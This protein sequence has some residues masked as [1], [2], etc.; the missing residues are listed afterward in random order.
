MAYLVDYDS[1]T[2]QFTHWT[3]FAYPNGVVGQDYITHFQGISSA[4][5]A[6]TRSAADSGQSGSANA[7]PG[8]V[9]DRPAQSRRLVRSRR[10]GRS[11]LSRRRS[12]H[13]RHQRRFGGRQPGGRVRHRAATGT[14]SFQATVNI[15]FQL[16]NVIS[17]NGGNG[18]GIYG[19]ERQS[20]RHERHR[21]GCQR[22]AQARQREER[23]P[24]H[25]RR[26]GKSDRR[27]GDRRQR[28]HGERVRPSAPGQPDLGQPWPTACSSTTGPPRRC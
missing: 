9:G 20:D 4:E 18:I 17:G 22:H 7:A 21:H 28:S 24:R 26:G 13:E 27:P 25:G 1:A 14:F 5:A 15:G 6:F 19:A 23:H 2:G 3:S 11:Q 8:L 12:G 16:S 10:L